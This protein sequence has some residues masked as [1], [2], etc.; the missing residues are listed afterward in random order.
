MDL[1]RELSAALDVDP[2]PDFVARVRARVA[3]EAPPRE[4]R[5]G[6]LV[7]LGIGAAV[8][9]A[10]VFVAPDRNH[11]GSTTS[12]PAA[13]HAAQPPVT[14][15]VPATQPAQLRDRAREMPEVVVNAAARA[16]FEELAVALQDGEVDLTSLVSDTTFIPVEPM[17]VEV[18]QPLTDSEG[19]H[20]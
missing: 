19:V 17:V 8:V 5:L 4:L 1:D 12:A 18:V 9:A 16:G 3:D 15:P 20:Q 10:M 14:V 11:E 13:L 2:S 6:P 7:A